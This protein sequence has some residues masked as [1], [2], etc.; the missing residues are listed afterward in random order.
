MQ[1]IKHTNATSIDVKFLLYFIFFVSIFRCG[2]ANFVRAVTIGL[3]SIMSKGLCTTTTWLCYICIGLDILEVPEISIFWIC[4]NNFICPITMGSILWKQRI[5]HYYFLAVVYLYRVKY[6]CLI[7]IGS[8][9]SL[10]KNFNLYL[11][12]LVMDH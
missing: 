8:V 2:N 5:A 12:Y 11:Y 3:V 6:L 4:T 1:N 7:I 9:R 10:H